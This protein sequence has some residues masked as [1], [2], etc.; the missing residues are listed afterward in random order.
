MHHKLESSEDGRHIIKYFKDSDL[1]KLEATRSIEAFDIC[2]PCDYL[3][4][5]KVISSNDTSITFAY[6]S[7]AIRIADALIQ[8]FE[9]VLELIPH[10][11][12][13]FVFLENHLKHSSKISFEHLDLL[14]HLDQGSPGT[15][16]HGDYSVHNLLIQKNSLLLVDWSS[17]IWGGKQ[18]THAPEHW[19]LVWFILS[20][21]LIPH[22]KQLSFKQRDLVA[23][24]LLNKYL[25]YAEISQPKNLASFAL[26][27]CAYFSRYNR[28]NANWYSTVKHYPE[29]YH[30]A[31]FWKR[32]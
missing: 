26:S 11:A 30:C 14:D 27:H 8:N 19:D 32:V 25:E 22:I 10:I 1:L 5:P 6:H 17:S 13:S 9:Q 29:W 23:S 7:D 18:F 21:Y 16:V 28:Q 2:K 4:T 3:S 24:E 31:R 12:K 15:F 20:I